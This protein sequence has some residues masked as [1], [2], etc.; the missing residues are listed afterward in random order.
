MKSPCMNCN[1]RS[2]GC[3]TDCVLYKKYRNA[4]DEYNSLLRK[5]VEKENMFVDYYKEKNRRHR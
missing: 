1:K 5:G 3:H 2:V 4:L